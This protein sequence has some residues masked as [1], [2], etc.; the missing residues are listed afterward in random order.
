MIFVNK[1]NLHPICAI[2]ANKKENM[3]EIARPISKYVERQEIYAVMVRTMTI[4]HLSSSQ[5]N[6]AGTMEHHWTTY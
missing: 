1:S 4:N 3:V 2:F 5:I 6:E